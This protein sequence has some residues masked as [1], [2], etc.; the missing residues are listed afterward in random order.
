MCQVIIG[1]VLALDITLDGRS[2]GSCSS[3]S[4]DGGVNTT[5]LLPVD[6][7]GH[8]ADEIIVADNEQVALFFQRSVFC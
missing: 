7:V 6:E 5:R 1:I 4:H 8:R 3:C 2:R